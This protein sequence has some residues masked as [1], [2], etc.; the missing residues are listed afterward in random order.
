MFL[1]A[2]DHSGSTYPSYRATGIAAG[3]GS[4][5]EQLENDAKIARGTAEA[6]NGAAGA[7]SAGAAVASRMGPTGKAVALM[8]GGSAAAAKMAAN[9]AANKARELEKQAQIA[10]ENEKRAA[11]KAAADKA[12]ADKAAADKAAADKAAADK[13]AEQYRDA[14]DRNM[15][16]HWE[17]GQ[18]GGR[19][20][21]RNPGRADM[22]SRTA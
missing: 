22:I 19:A 1:Q 4:R 2:R 21:E 20:S 18:Y 5:A 10:R 14:L 12:A 15:R 16:E 8:M 11:E 7:L 3:T 17:R 13:Q 9:N 6:L